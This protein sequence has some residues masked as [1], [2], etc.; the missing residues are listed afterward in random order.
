MPAGAL[1]TVPDPVVVTDTVTFGAGAKVAVT[2]GADD[3]IVKL[4]VPAPEHGPLQPARTDPVAANA[5]S[6]TGLPVLIAELM[7]VPEV[8]PAVAVQLIPP[9][10]LTV[11]FPAPAAETVTGNAVGMK[12]ALTDCDELIVTEQAPVPEQAP[13]QPLKTEPAAAVGVR[14]TIVP[15]LKVSVQVAPQ[16]MTPGELVMDPDPAPDNKT[17]RET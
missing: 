8:A 17:V 4:H 16:L 14:V 3:P 6:A 13:P 12:L 9:V 15:W 2:V 10:P 1:V 5:V 11:P 7:H